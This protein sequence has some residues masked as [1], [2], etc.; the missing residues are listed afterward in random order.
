MLLGLG[1]TSTLLRVRNVN[2]VKIKDVY[3]RFFFPKT[4]DTTYLKLLN[5]PMILAAELAFAGPLNIPAEFVH[6][7]VETVDIVL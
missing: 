2:P 1:I 6:E 5:S 7:V 4:W 3:G